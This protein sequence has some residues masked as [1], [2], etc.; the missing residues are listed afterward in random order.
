MPWREVRL[1]LA[2]D[3]VWQGSAKVAYKGAAGNGL[4]IDEEAELRYRHQPEGLDLSVSNDG[5]FFQRIVF[6]NGMLYRKAQNG[7]PIASK[8]LETKR[9]HH[10]DAAFALA[11]TGWNLL[12]RFIS[13]KPRGVETI[14]GRQASCYSIGLNPNPE[15]FQGGSAKGVL[16]AMKGW[17]SSLV[18]ESVAGDLCVD[19]ATAVLL[20]V[21]LEGRALRP[22]D[23]G[24]ATLEVS[25]QARFVSIAV[26]P[27]INAPEEFLKSLKRRRRKRP[28]TDF[29]E[30]QGVRVLEGPDAG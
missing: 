25:V 2:T 27:T 18:A 4:A 5:G 13:L 17:R 6:S 11:A 20:K 22:L 10:A 19:K 24:A 1:R 9:Y 16:G 30:Q 15:P 14:A 12:D 8:D 23:A 28:A 3:Q 26:A 7:D 29:L 21:Q